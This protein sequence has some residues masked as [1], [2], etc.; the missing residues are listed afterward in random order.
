VWLAGATGNPL[1]P[2]HVEAARHWTARS[3]DRTQVPKP[4]STV[5]V[6]IGAPI[7]VP[8]DQD[9]DTIERKRLELEE[10]LFALEQ[11]AAN[12]LKSEP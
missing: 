11:R 2:F 8:A 12:L 7:E 3:W 1:L 5:A 10:A 9:A 6:A 4:F